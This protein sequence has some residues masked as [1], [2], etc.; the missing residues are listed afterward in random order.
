MNTSYTSPHQIVYGPGDAISFI[1]PPADVVA[2][3]AE[4]ARRSKMTPEELSREPPTLLTS[5]TPPM[6]GTT[7]PQSFGFAEAGDRAGFNQ[8]P[9]GDY[10]P[11]D[12][13]DASAA[14][15]R[16]RRKRIAGDTAKPRVRAATI[17]TI[18]NRREAIEASRLLIAAFQEAADY[19]QKR[20]HNQ[21]PPAL[22]VDDDRY[23]L[24]VREIVADLHK[25]VELL[26][27][28]KPVRATP[29]RKTARRF[30]KFI[31]AYQSTLGHGVAAL[32]AAGIGG[33]LLHFG[34]LPSEFS[35]LKH[36]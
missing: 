32:T 31:D 13:V 26:E 20:H 36:K 16:Q 19:D 6:A 1:P 17:I 30:G 15:P 5:E 33:W 35:I 18:A 12:A 28:S 22:W 11:E 23:L 34:V 4:V 10:T 2:Y 14:R 25:I 8:G 29:V 21:S 24:D 7:R 27:A 3:Q 9:F